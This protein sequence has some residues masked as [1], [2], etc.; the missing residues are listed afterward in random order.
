[1]IADT[2][3]ANGRIPAASGDYQHQPRTESFSELFR[4]L[5]GQ[6]KVWAKKESE[7]AKVELAESASEAKAGVTKALCGVVFLLAALGFSI[8][9]ATVAVAMGLQAAGMGMQGSYAI[10]IFL[11][12]A[13]SA[14]VGWQSF[15]AAKRKLNPR[16]LWP[17]ET[18]ASLK[19][20]TQWARE[21]I[22]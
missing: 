22:R 20:S 15:K 7:L 9:F 2:N 13:I 1:M 16:H 6:A 11:I 5:S 21:K 17:S 8:A 3:P 4:D 19:E 12:G 18:A 10:S 14:L